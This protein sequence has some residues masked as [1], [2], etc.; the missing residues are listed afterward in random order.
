MPSSATTTT[1]YRGRSRRAGRLFVA[2]RRGL[3]LAVS[4]GFLACTGGIVYL[5]LFTDPRVSIN[6]LA[7]YLLAGFGGLFGFWSGGYWVRLKLSPEG[8]HPRDSWPCTRQA[9]LGASGVMTA[10]LAMRSGSLGIPAVVLTAAAMVAL[11]AFFTWL[12]AKD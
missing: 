6:Q 3:F 11:E 9:L 5:L 8:E 10:F 7:F 12:G 2:W 1:E 4:L